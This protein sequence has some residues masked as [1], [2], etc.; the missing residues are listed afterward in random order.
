MHLDSTLVID[1]ASDSTT[2]EGAVWKVKSILARSLATDFVNVLK[3]NGLDH[4]IDAFLSAIS[5]ENNLSKLL[6][7]LS[8][9]MTP[10]ILRQIS[11]D[12]QI[13]MG[14]STSLFQML[15][16]TLFELKSG[17]MLVDQVYVLSEVVSQFEY[18]VI[19][20]RE[21]VIMTAKLYMLGT[22][23][24]NNAV[25]CNQW[26][27]LGFHSHIVPA[28]F[29]RS[30]VSHDRLVLFTEHLSEESVT[31]YE[32]FSTISIIES[33]QLPEIIMR[34]I[35]SLCRAV[36]FAHSSSVSHLDIHPGNILL[37]PQ[38]QAAA[39]ED[40]L[41]AENKWKVMLT[42]FLV[43]KIAGQGIVP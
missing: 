34:Y 36:E 1:Y 43:D 5:I 24:D 30:L 12:F 40:A 31:L 11:K 10:N 9:D 18:T 14:L 38:W 33:S 39:S 8:H 16:S 41:S 35:V 4:S 21:N 20:G 15:R 28:Y 19:Y 42:N 29:T 17:G 23:Y 27:T 3:H 37:F 25:R 6:P 2:T 7:I 26:I 32:H 13:P 22:E